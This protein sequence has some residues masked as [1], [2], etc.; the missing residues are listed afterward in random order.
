MRN[1]AYRLPRGPLPSSTGSTLK[2]K[3]PHKQAWLPSWLAYGFCRLVYALKGGAGSGVQDSVLKQ[4]PSEL[5]GDVSSEAVLSSRCASCCA[6]GSNAVG[7]AAATW[8]QVSG[9]DIWEVAERLRERRRFYI[10]SN[11][12]SSNLGRL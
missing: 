3:H 8:Q 2:P 11:V 7:T 9:H 4:W 1:P 5:P 10:R 12:D 6:N